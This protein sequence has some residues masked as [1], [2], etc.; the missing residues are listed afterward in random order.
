MTLLRKTSKN[1]GTKVNQLQLRNSFKKSKSIREEN[2]KDAEVMKIMEKYDKELMELRKTLKDKEK[3]L[4][5][6][7]MIAKIEEEREKALA[8]VSGSPHNN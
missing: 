2:E 1:I 6:T 8:A 7:K 3:N 4:L 5:I